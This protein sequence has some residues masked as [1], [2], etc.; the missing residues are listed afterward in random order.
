RLL[1]GAPGGTLRA[2]PLLSGRNYHSLHRE[3]PAFRFDAREDGGRVTWQPYPD[4][5]EIVAATNARY[6]HQ[7]DWYRNFL[8]REEQA[9]GLDAIE[10]LASPGVFTW[11]LAEGAAFLL[12]STESPPNTG[13]IDKYVSRLLADERQRRAAFETGLHR[14]A[15][16]YL[17]RRGR[18]W[19]IVAG[20]PW[21][22]DWGRDTF[23]SL[24]GLCLATGR[25]DRARD[26]LVEWAGA[27]SEG[28]LPNR[29]ADRGEAPEF[30][31]V[32]ASLWYVIA[33]QA[34]LD[35]AEGRGFALKTGDRGRLE[36]AMLDIVEGYARG[37]RHGIGMD[38]DALVAAGVPGLQLT[39]MDARVGDWVVTPRIGKPVEIQ[40]LWV[41]A[42]ASVARLG[43]RWD[44]VRR[45]AIESFN[46][47]FWNEDR[48]CLFDVVDAD[49]V[50]GRVDSSLRPNQIFAVGGLPLPLVE[51]T[52]ARRIVDVVEQMLLTPVGLR[53]LAPSEPGYVSRY[54]GGVP[55]RDG[56]Y[57]RGTVW[58]WLIAPFVDA[59]RKT[60]TTADVS[61]DPAIFLEPLRRHLD[62]AGFGHVSEI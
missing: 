3:N 49:H 1:D 25:L 50:P 60:R 13:P 31:A 37:T 51:G 59:W 48:G 29:F 24:P 34:F 27:V 23:I 26:I 61:T 41:N 32:D 43:R 36:R 22:T 2:R 46:E 21:F 19:T 55:E 11:D 45:Q 12:L 14:S 38:P 40:A 62:E 6:Q 33:A 42:L 58:P 15:D 39:W 20:Y 57:H 5:P 16:T 28:M 54:E 35:A 10:D 47:K 56:A 17:V 8:Y 4:L 53:S 9:R 44:D 30:N 7:P 52:R 18:G